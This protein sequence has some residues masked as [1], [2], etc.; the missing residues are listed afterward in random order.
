MDYQYPAIQKLQRKRSKQKKQNTFNLQNYKIN[1]QRPQTNESQ[2]LPALD[3]AIDFPTPELGAS[4]AVAPSGCGSPGIEASID[5]PVSGVGATGKQEGQAMQPRQVGDKW[6]TCEKAIKSMQPGT[7]TAYWE[8]GKR[9]TVAFS[10]HDNRRQETS[11][12]MEQSYV[13]RASC[14]E[15]HNIP[16]G[17]LG[18]ALQE[19]KH[20]QNI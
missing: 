4:K 12:T 8:T 15:H 11:V 1:L 7:P 16:L 20:E 9:S 13:P 2:L 5:L 17:S 14:P 6:E 19:R 18:K 3:V 10:E